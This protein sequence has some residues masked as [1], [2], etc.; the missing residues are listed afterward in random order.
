MSLSLPT[1]STITGLLL[2]S[3]LIRAQPPLPTVDAVDLNRYAGVWY[4]VAR[5]PMYFQRKCSSDVHA[6]YTPQADGSV[7]VL[8]RCR[9]ANGQWLSAQGIARS[10]DASNSRLRVTFLPKGWRW[11]PVGHAPYWIIRLDGD[12]QTAMVGH[13][14]RRYLWILSRQP[15]MADS[16]YQDYVQQAQALGFATDKLIRTEHSPQAH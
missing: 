2:A 3:S 14:D 6:E 12:Y 9:Q 7:G 13:P 5:L 1:L 4:E 15:Q 10:T 8:N 11:L 16:T